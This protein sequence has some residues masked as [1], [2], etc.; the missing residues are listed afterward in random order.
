M[1]GNDYAW[2]ASESLDRIAERVRIDVADVQ[3]DGV[4]PAHAVFT[5]VA[6]TT[7]PVDVLR[8]TIN[9]LPL[10][11][12]P[13][14]MR[15]HA[16]MRVVFELASHY[17]R[18]NLTQPQQSRFIHHVTAIHEGVAYAHLVTTMLGDGDAAIEPAPAAS[19]VPIAEEPV[20]VR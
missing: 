10:G 19:R 16:A 12:D 18:V 2:T 5:I 7:G 4:I 20:L 14:R 1:V 3:A 15:T 8:T 13:D 17:N 9:G 11:I 6:D